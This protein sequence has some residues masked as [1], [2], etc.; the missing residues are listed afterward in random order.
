[1]HGKSGSLQFRIGRVGGMILT[2][3]VMIASAM[4]ILLQMARGPRARRGL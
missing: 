3:V 4:L 2:E 1:M